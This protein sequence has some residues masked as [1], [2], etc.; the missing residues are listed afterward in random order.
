MK[1]SPEGIPKKS[2]FK[3]FITKHIIL[4]AI[5]LM[6]FTIRAQNI[7]APCGK[8]HLGFGCRYYG[9]IAANYRNYGFIKTKFGAVVNRKIVSSSDFAYYI[10]HPSQLFYILLGLSYN[11]FGVHTW[12]LRIIPIIFSMGGLLLIYLITKEKWNRRTALFASFFFSIVPMAAIYGP[13]ID[14]TGSP[15]LFAILLILFFY[16]KWEVGCHKIFYWLMVVSFFI[17]AQTEWA[18]YFVIPAIVLHHIL[19]AKKIKKKILLLPLWGVLAFLLYI[20]Y[21]KILTG[22]FIGEGSYQGSLFWALKVRASNIASDANH[23]LRFTARMFLS[24]FWR[25]IFDMYTHVLVFLSSIWVV[26]L[27]KKVIWKKDVKN[28]I[29][30]LSIFL[31]GFIYIVAFKQAAW[32]HDFCFVY[33]LPWFVISSAVVVEKICVKVPD[34]I[35]KIVVGFILVAFAVLSLNMTLLRLHKAYGSHQGFI[36]FRE[37]CGKTTK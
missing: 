35:A 22:S 32:I 4:F 28:D 24:Y 27:I 14:A 9:N 6:A 30:L 26:L 5:L 3:K 20:G 12:N 1:K 25:T 34:K 23:S 37:F 13:H 29:F 31:I 33:L 16:S 36:E 8:G 11:V 17:G 18:V 7:T 10:H 19:T 2:S 21:I 15:S